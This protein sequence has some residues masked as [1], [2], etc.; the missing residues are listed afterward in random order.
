V[1]DVRDVLP[2]DVVFSQDPEDW[3]AVIVKQDY[4]RH[5][6]VRLYGKA[7][8]GAAPS[9]AF[10]GVSG[11]DS[12][13]AWIGDANGGIADGDGYEGGYMIIEGTAPSEEAAQ[14]ARVNWVGY[15]D[16]GRT[17]IQVFQP[18][19]ITVREM[20]G[21]VADSSKG[22]GCDSGF[23]LTASVAFAALAAVRYAGKR[24]ARDISIPASQRAE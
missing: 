12:P 24:H 14:D 8:D 22:G 21:G 9:E 20:S 11:I 23:G 4:A 18:N 13:R 5:V 2:G 7:K 16:Q 10:A 1:Y 6:F 3:I 15:D 19:P 17:L